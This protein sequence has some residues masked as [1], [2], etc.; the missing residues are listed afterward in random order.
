MLLFKHGGGVIHMSIS[1]REVFEMRL[2]QYEML[3]K[4]TKHSVK[5]KKIQQEIDG[6]KRILKV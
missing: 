5:R 3:L 2:E 6:M 1:L 4:Y